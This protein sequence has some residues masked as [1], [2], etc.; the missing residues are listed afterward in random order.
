MPASRTK[1]IKQ[2]AQWRPKKEI[3]LVPG[4]TRG[5]YA[6]LHF[7][8]KRR[9]KKFDVVYIGMAP[10]GGIL[11][12][13][14][15][16]RKSDKTWTHFSIF[17]VWDNVSENEVAELEGLFR[18]IYRKDKRA[19][20]FNKQKNA[21]KSKTFG[22][23]TLHPGEAQRVPS[24]SGLPLMARSSLIDGAVMEK[25]GPDFIRRGRTI[26]KMRQIHFAL[27]H[28]LARVKQQI[29][30]LLLTG[31]SENFIRDMLASELFKREP[32]VARDYRC[33]AR[34][35]DIAFLECHHRQ[36]GKRPSCCIELKQ[37]YLK[38]LGE[39]GR[40]RYFEN[41]TKDMKSR[42]KVCRDVYGI[43]LTRDVPVVPKGA[44]GIF[45]HVE[46]DARK[47]GEGLATTERYLLS[48]KKRKKIG[49]FFPQGIHEAQVVSAKCHGAKVNLYAWVVRVD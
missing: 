36:K 1:F 23:M 12:R 16:H 30:Y 17:Q 44:V 45:K 9:V 25:N 22:K 27:V 47:R 31:S 38:D 15:S 10:S 29:G 7:R 39:D 5:I 3:D 8:P 19:N 37:L 41:L 26:M 24:R 42:K 49:E 28:A 2:C 46:A 11:S 34:I 43:V 6:L 4:G 48:M 20:R 14:R 18:E 33:G 13:L 32:C 40:P 35:L 21:R